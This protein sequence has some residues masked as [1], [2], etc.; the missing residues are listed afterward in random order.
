MKLLRILVI[1]AAVAVLVSPLLRA[2]VYETNN[3][4]CTT[5]IVVV[6]QYTFQN[7]SLVNCPT[8]EAP[9]AYGATLSITDY[10]HE[11]YVPDQWG[12]LQYQS[13]Q[14]HFESQ[15][16]YHV[17]APCPPSIPLPTAAVTRPKG[18]LAGLS[19][20]FNTETT[21]QH[22]KERVSAGVGWEITGNSIAEYYWK[23]GCVGIAWIAMLRKIYEGSQT[24][25]PPLSDQQFPEQTTT[26]ADNERYG[27]LR[28]YNTLENALAGECAPGTRRV[29]F[30]KIGRWKNDTPPNPAPNGEIPLDSV[31]KRADNTF[32]YWTYLD[33][34][35]RSLEHGE[36][37]G[38]G[39]PKGLERDLTPYPAN[40]A[41]GIIY[42]KRCVPNHEW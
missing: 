24:A 38:E 22:Q 19:Y 17:S 29:L 41:D 23:R 10:T 16:S 36:I 5:K 9:L 42:F 27:L 30:A 40:P 11:Y 4:P 35:W 20:G 14:V 33:G 13:Y 1:V 12:N 21:M 26:Y 6:K 25:I 31:T 39:E 7:G 18:G 32:S 8:W 37:A 34:K 3:T 2:D 15:Y 28:G